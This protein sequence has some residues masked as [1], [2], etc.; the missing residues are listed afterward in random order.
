MPLRLLFWNCC[1]APVRGE[2]KRAPKDVAK[3]IDE[4]FH[5]GVELVALCEVDELAMKAIRKE[6]RTRYVQKY[7]LTE[8]VGQT[9]WDMGIL[10]RSSLS[11]VK[12]MPALGRDEGQTIRGGHSVYVSSKINDDEFRLYLVHWP[13]RI[14]GNSHK[15]RSRASRTLQDRVRQNLREGTPVV[16]LGDF[17]DEPFDQSLTELKT[18]RD[19]RRVLERPKSWLYNPSWHLAAPSR[20]DPW[21][22]FGSYSYARGETSTRYLYDQALTSAHFLDEKTE[23]AP[24]VKFVE[25]PSLQSE[26]LR[27]S[28]HIPL[29]LTL[30]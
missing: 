28:D 1:V 25:L 10:Y 29:E 5:D 12:R 17:N 21:A 20:S 6:T 27:T 4:A 14:Y 16:V 9:R 22:S 13:S 19:P 7:E 24:S 23:K 30:P 11:C 15:K 3:V 26:H 18:S 2:G 8:P